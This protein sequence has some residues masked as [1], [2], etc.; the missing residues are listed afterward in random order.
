MA[1]QGELPNPP[2]GNAAGVNVGSSIVG[3]IDPGTMTYT[4]LVDVPT[5]AQI[6]AATVAV[7]IGDELWTGSF[8]GDRV[9]RYPASGLKD[10]KR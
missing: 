3:R 10:T 6:N 1:G 2:P 8:R 9:A 5:G 4:T 7:Q